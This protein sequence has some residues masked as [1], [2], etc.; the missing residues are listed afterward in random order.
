MKNFDYR[1]PKSLDEVSNILEHSE[2]QPRFLAGGTDLV[3]AMRNHRLQPGLVI[4]TKRVHELNELSFDDHVMTLGASV[5][6]RTLCQDAQVSRS[7]P[8]LI[9]CAT[10]IGGTQ[11][12]GRATLGGNLCN[13]APS[14][15]TVPVLIV[16]SALAN[17]C[18]PDG[19][20]EVPVEQFCT[21]PGKT[22]LGPKDILV[23]LRVP[24]PRDREGARFLRFIPRKDMDIAIA[25]AAANVVVSNNGDEF[26]KARIAIGAVG[27]TPLHV[28]DAAQKLSGQPVSDAVI[29][30]AASTAR[31]AARPISD[32]RGT[33]DQRKHLTEVL[34]RRA[35]NG[36]LER[37]RGVT[38]E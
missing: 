19:F 25:N 12:Q 4:D 2:L 8:A 29:A 6:C 28:S 20:R 36:A 26:R 14:A 21:G 27:P 22:V 30:R 24:L 33:V 18:G 31:E 16:L 38:H 1:M 9:D 3:V 11:T 13:A 37:A 5:T 10:L 32:M 17:I 35:L 23:S 34:V 15:D 7:F